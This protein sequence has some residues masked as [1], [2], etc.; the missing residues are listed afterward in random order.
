MFDPPSI[1]AAERVLELCQ[2]RE[3][4]LVTAESCTGGLV[5][6]C[7]SEIPG[8]S[9]V[10]VG[11]FIPYTAA[12]KRSMLDLDPTLIDKH[13]TVSQETTEAL[14]TAALAATEA[15]L[16]LAVTGWASPGQG[17]P[18]Q[19]VGEV[20]LATCFRDRSPSSEVASFSGD[21]TEV[22]RQA[23]HSALGMLTRSLEAR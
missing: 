19:A 12:T 22:R 10:L 5:A 20:H 21:R 13:G 7:L 2:A 17:V 11:G 18:D 14:A 4:T 9:K 23:V 16:S 3:L 8:A 15:D 1:R 6:G